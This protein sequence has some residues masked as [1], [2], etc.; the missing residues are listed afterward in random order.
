MRADSLAGQIIAVVSRRAPVFQLTSAGSMARKIDTIISR[1]ATQIQSR[2]YQNVSAKAPKPKDRSRFSDLPGESS[3]G[4]RARKKRTNLGDETERLR[5]AGISTISKPDPEVQIYEHG[6]FTTRISLAIIGAL[7]AVASAIIP[8]VLTE[9]Q[10]DSP[11][12]PPPGS[13]SSSDPCGLERLGDNW[14]QPASEDYNE[15]VFSGQHRP[16][17]YTQVSPDSDPEV[18]VKGNLSGLK[19][20]P[21]EVLYLFRRPDSKTKD[22]FGNPGNG[23]YYPATPVTPTS[24]GCWEDD[25]RPVGYPGSRGIGQ[26]YMLVLVSRGQAA[27]FPADR[28]AKGWDGY[29]A[30]QWRGFNDLRIMSFYVST[31]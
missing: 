22:A 17:V 14:I 27:K 23:R 16:V 28:A 21:D 12:A 7:A 19:V 13:I 26:E 6:G 4:G 18:S 25:N 5:T 20:P 31:A 15:L 11:P 1:R 29:S 2:P 3:T 10:V 9:H 24:D 30:S 8:A